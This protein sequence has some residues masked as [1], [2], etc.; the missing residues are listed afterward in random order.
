M[1]PVISLSIIP[2]LAGIQSAAEKMD[3]RFR[4]YDDFTGLAKVLITQ[5]R[6]RW[7]ATGRMPVL[8]QPGDYSPARQFEST[9]NGR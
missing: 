5:L 2:V 1:Q 9:Q 6:V 8:P 4:G 7:A 3:T